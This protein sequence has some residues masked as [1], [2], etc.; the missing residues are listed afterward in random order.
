[1]NDITT[2]KSILNKILEVFNKQK[3]Q[4]EMCQEHKIN[5]LYFCND[6][7]ISLCSDCYLFENTHKDHQ[8]KHLDEIYKNHL[9]GV[10]FEIN[11]L[12]GKLE[13]L[14]NFLNLIEEKI[15]YVRQVKNEKNTE[16]EELYEYLKLKSHHFKYLD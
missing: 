1:M 13:K 8:I 3:N 10:K 5:L 9:D 6:C 14:N 11:D 4:T 12:Q 2:V 15:D 7:N 16:L